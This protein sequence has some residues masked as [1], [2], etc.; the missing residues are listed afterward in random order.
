M[1]K[2]IQAGAK[3]KAHNRSGESGKVK[4]ERKILVKEGSGVVR[5]TLRVAFWESPR[6]VWF[7]QQ[8]S[9]RRGRTRRGGRGN[10]AGRAGGRG[11]GGRCRAVAG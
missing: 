3:I 2:E 4:V 1:Q 5:L 10:G 7:E 9:P 8:A 11:M 6:R